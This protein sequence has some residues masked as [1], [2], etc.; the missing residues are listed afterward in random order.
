MHKITV[1][2]LFQQ[3]VVVQVKGSRGLDLGSCSS[4]PLEVASGPV[5]GGIGLVELPGAPPPF[6]GLERKRL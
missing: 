2:I 1:A 5:V 6:L 3:G 4:V